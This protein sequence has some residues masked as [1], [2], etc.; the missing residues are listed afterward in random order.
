MMD[1]IK[2]VDEVLS[3]YLAP[4]WIAM[5]YLNLMMDKIKLVDDLATAI[6][7]LITI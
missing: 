2:L 4:V 1:K 6:F 7:K 3:L 5:N